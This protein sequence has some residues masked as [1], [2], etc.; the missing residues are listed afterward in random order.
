MLGAVHLA[1][2]ESERRTGCA[3]HLRGHVML[4]RGKRLRYRKMS[5]RLKAHDGGQVVPES[6]RARRPAHPAGIDR[7]RAAR[8]AQPPAAQV[9]EVDRLFE[10]PASDAP[11]IVAPAA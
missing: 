1:I 8:L 9:E 6:G 7:D 3:Y 11:R 10:R 4:G 2:P 5:A